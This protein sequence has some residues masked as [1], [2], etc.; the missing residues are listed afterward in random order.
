MVT[1]VTG[2]SLN[3]E[4]TEANCESSLVFSRSRCKH[5]ACLRAGIVYVLGGKDANIP[6]NDFWSYDIGSLMLQFGT[7]VK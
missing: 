7:L 5:A 6:L 3:D 4:L 1:R 2:W